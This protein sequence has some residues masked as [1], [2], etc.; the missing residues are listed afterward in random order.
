VGQLFISSNAQASFGA[1]QVLTRLASIQYDGPP[2][3]NAVMVWHANFVQLTPIPVNLA[4]FCVRRGSVGGRLL[5][6]EH[7][8]RSPGAEGTGTASGV[9]VGDLQTGQTVELI[10][11]VDNPGALALAQN[12]FTVFVL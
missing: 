6:A 4:G 10:G 9:L 8:L 2:L 12:G 7:T 11:Y 5:I 3:V 1:N